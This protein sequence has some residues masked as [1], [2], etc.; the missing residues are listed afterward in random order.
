MRRFDI[1]A[2]AKALFPHDIASPHRFTCLQ[3]ES[4]LELSQEKIVMAR[5]F[6][7]ACCIPI[8]LSLSFPHTLESGA[9][10]SDFLSLTVS[11]MVP[12]D[13]VTVTLSV[14]VLTGSAGSGCSMSPSSFRLLSSLSSFAYRADL[15][16]C[17]AGTYQVRTSSMLSGAGSDRYQVVF[18]TENRFEMRDLSALS[19]SIVSAYFADDLSGVNVQVHLA[20]QHM[21]VR[22]APH[23]S[24]A[25]QPQFTIPIE[26]ASA[27]TSSSF[28]CSSV[29][30]LVDDP[31]A[32]CRLS[33][34]TRLTI[35][36]SHGSAILPGSVFDL[37]PQQVR[38][39]GSVGRY[40]IA[41][42]VVTAAPAAP[43]SPVVTINAPSTQSYCQQLVIDLS[44]SRF[45][46][47]I[48]TLHCQN[49]R[50]IT[51]A[52]PAVVLEGGLGRTF[53]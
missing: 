16:G 51:S 15:Y 29:M 5:N 47:P 52:I 24:L 44:S 37:L 27:V 46:I 12:S 39:A 38:A 35:V 25:L 34:T 43:A 7:T 40:A 23:L 11:S 8:H 17:A 45:S 42:S 6:T 22:L 36:L 31:L 14:D 53:Q 50:W 49:L 19:P 4:A 30:R 3:T 21:G 20:P 28:R 48:L 13:D 9:Y 2:T 10:V 26:V 1:I 18:D 41:Q 33:D 32:M